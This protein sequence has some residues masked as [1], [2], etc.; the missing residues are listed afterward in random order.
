ME[1]Y[2]QWASIRYDIHE[3]GQEPDRFWFFV[4]LLNHFHGHKLHERYAVFISYELL[5]T[6]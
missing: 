6:T 2:H 5:K 3:H 4:T 1:R